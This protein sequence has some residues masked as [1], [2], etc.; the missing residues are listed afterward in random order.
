MKIVTLLLGFSLVSS[1]AVAFGQQDSGGSNFFRALGNAAR[2]SGDAYQNSGSSWGS[3]LNQRAQQA[4]Q[5]QYDSNRQLQQHRHEQR[6]N[7]WNN[8]N[9]RPVETKCVSERNGFGQI[10]S[11]CESQ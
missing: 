8:Y 11:R 1:S 3:Q 4:Q 6:Q 10:V 5:H 2:G 9:S 7:M